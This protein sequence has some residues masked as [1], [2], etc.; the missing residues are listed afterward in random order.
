MFKK[1]VVVVDFLS[2]YPWRQLPWLGP[3]LQT[4]VVDITIGW[5]ELRSM[6]KNIVFLL[7]AS[8]EA[9]EDRYKWQMQALVYWHLQTK[10][11]ST[12]DL[13]TCK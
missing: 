10:N 11:F 4:E 7:A 3:A 13:K 12:S 2:P 1:F 6:K 8:Y 9:K 5:I